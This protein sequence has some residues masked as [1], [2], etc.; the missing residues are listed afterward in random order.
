MTASSASSPPDGGI[1]PARPADAPR[2]QAIA[3]RAI[4]H[5]YRR[6]L[7]NKAVDYYLESGA[8]DREVAR[9][10]AHATV[11]E[12]EDGLL[13]FYVVLEDLLHLLIVDPPAQGRG[14]GA[15][16]LRAAEAAIAAEGHARARLEIHAGNEAAQRFYARHGWQDAGFLADPDG[17]ARRLR[18]EKHL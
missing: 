10:I 1:R 4:D 5:G 2:L 11:A 7:G 18:M 3:C 17:L 6:F 13:G 9:H 15:Q 8:S 16:L 14:V 12:G